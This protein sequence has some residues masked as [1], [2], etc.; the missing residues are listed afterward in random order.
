VMADEVGRPAAYREL[1]DAVIA[2]DPDRARKAAQDLLEPATT[3]LLTAI[4]NLEE[5]R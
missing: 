3:A 5:Q 1:A 2:G 4:D